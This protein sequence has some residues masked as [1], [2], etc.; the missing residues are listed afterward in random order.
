MQTVVLPAAACPCER[1][2]WPGLV[3]LRLTACQLAMLRHRPPQQI[4]S[5]FAPAP[6]LKL[7]PSLRRYGSN[8]HLVLLVTQLVARWRQHVAAASPHRRMSGRQLRGPPAAGACWL[9]LCALG[10]VYRA[11]EGF[12]PDPQATNYHPDALQEHAQDCEY[13]CLELAFFFKANAALDP[14]SVPECTYVTVDQVEA[15]V[16][17][18]TDPSVLADREACG[19][20]ALGT[21]S[22]ATDCGAV[23]LADDPNTAA[24]THSVPDPAPQAVVSGE[25]RV[26]IGTP[27]VNLMARRLE[28]TGPRANA[29]LRYIR[30]RAMADA[31]S[32][33]GA[34]AV[35]SG[36][37]TVFD[38][39]F[40]DNAAGTEGGAIVGRDS[41]VAVER[42]IF[43]RN[44]AARGG[45]VA[46]LDST[47]RTD[48]ATFQLNTATEH[49]GAVYAAQGSVSTDV[50]VSISYTEFQDN[51]AD[52]A[53]LR[54]GSAGTNAGDD[55]TA[56][57][58][59]SYTDQGTTVATCVATHA[60]ACAALGGA[61]TQA[62]DDCTADARCTYN[63]QGTC[64]GD[65]TPIAA[66]CGA[67]DDGD[68]VACAV[69]ADGD[70][71]EV[72]TDREKMAAVATHN[73]PAAVSSGRPSHT[74]GQCHRSTKRVASDP[75]VLVRPGRQLAVAPCRL[76]HPK[77]LLA[78]GSCCC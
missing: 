68:G 5:P 47:L 41:S 20:V 37:V 76:D 66:S 57:A 22:S 62:G 70:A 65:A 78:A 32:G 72:A 33:G 15:C 39:I 16:E 40:E 29:A 63:T 3:C 71:C 69:N 56:D 75:C 45:A 54:I 23:R 21:A 60:A 55:C 14:T 28:V 35:Q 19:L 52:A 74:H 17:T 58:S 13:S 6:R 2:V 48:E 34:I 46:L 26:I 38:C 77:R 59:C 53:C 64:T 27:T 31:G 44:A 9:L 8:C 61:G 7:A 18:A 10:A 25:D 43:L 67:G 51:A 36:G 50:L 24:C 4:Y 1:W 42:T 73:T 49:G 11:S 30:I 12:C